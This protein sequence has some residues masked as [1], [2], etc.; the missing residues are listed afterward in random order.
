V[1][2]GSGATFLDHD[3]D[4]D[5]DLF[6]ANYLAFDLE[7]TPKKGSSGL[8]RWKDVAVNC[9]PRGLPTGRHSLYRNN[10][11]G[12]F[13]DITR[14]A[15]ISQAEPGYGM[16][17]VAA[18]FDG[19]G[20]VDI[21]L[22]CDGT[23]SLLFRNQGG[24]AFSEEGLPRGVALSQD[25]VEQAGMGVG[26][27]D[28]DVDG[29]LDIFKTHFAEDTNV[30][31]RN[32]GGGI[33]EDVTIRSGLAVET[34][35]V[36]WGAA[37]VD[38]DNDGLPDIFYATGGIY[39]EVERALP[40]IPQ[41]TPSVVFR[42]LDGRRFEELVSQAGPGVAEAHSS[43]GAAFADYDNDGDMDILVVNLNEPPTLLRNDLNSDAGRLKVELRAKP[44][45]SVLGAQVTAIYGDRRQ[46]QAV[47]AQ[48][49]FY[50]VN[51]RRIHFGL[52]AETKADL[53][54]RWPD[55][56]IEKLEDISANQWVVIEQ[57]KGVVSTKKL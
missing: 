51:D 28:F 46:R 26:V 36:G 29:E 40:Q 27:G 43:R 52:G 49:S 2:W 45:R 18:D 8:C 37:I 6:V 54:I 56:T 3:R 5:L 17:A 44:G 16:T 47:L 48:S 4:G 32:E 19:D 15:E 57:G 7:T 1:R 11:D 22:A 50:S 23:P 38:L 13:T 34:R 33:F 30:L 31:Y 55:G 24:K 20:W 9:G 42:N 14:E 12:T 35:F 53:E 39:P 41:K 21:Y 25:G 10:G